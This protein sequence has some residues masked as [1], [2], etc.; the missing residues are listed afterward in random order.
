[1]EITSIPDNFLWI[2]DSK[3]I[4][5]YIHIK[6]YIY[7]YIYIYI[8]YLHIYAIL[9]CLCILNLYSKSTQCNGK[10]CKYIEETCEFEYTNGHKYDIREGVINCNTDFAVYKFHCSSCSKQYVGS[11]IADFRY[12]F[13]NYKVH[14]VKCLS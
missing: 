5:I 11:N 3:Y 7:I 14:F 1:M 12:R 9:I 2:L 8:I 13:N 6:I 10:R 4:F